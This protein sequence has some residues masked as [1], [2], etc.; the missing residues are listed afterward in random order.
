MNGFAQFGWILTV[1][2]IIVSIFIIIAVSRHQARKRQKRQAMLATVANQ[3]GGSVIPGS[4]FKQPRLQFEYQGYPVSLEFY[5]TGG[6]NPTYY[7]LIVATFPSRPPF[8]L[9]IYPERFFSRLGK[10]LGGQDIQIGDQVFDEKFMIKGSSQEKVAGMLEQAGLRDAVFELRAMTMN[11]HIDIQTTKYGLRVKKLSWLDAPD[12]LL[13]FAKLG[14][15][16]ISGFLAAAGMSIVEEPV[17]DENQNRVCAVCGDQIEG[18]SV[19]CPRCGAPHHPECYE[20][21]DGCGK[22][23]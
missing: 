5:S 9:H 3:L 1:V 17:A 10:M 6:R 18:P 11:D 20:L 12:L 22:C 2:L 14:T 16:V 21:N 4:F 13:T 8:E 15:Q 23:Q 7:T 19:A